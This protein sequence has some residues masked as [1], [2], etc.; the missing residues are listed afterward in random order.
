MTIAPLLW[1]IMYTWKY[2]QSISIN[3]HVFLLKVNFKQYTRSNYWTSD[4][5]TTHLHLSSVV[6]DWTSYE[7]SLRESRSG[8]DL[9][10]L[11]LKCTESY[12]GIS[13]KH[14]GLCANKMEN[15]KLPI[16]TRS[17][18]H[19]VGKVVL[20]HFICWALTF[21]FITKVCNSNGGD[22]SRLLRSERFHKSCAV[23]RL[24]AFREKQLIKIWCAPTGVLCKDVVNTTCKFPPSKILTL[25]GCHAI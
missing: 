22:S 6:W 13:N 24:I 11:S 8:V 7:Y 2:R 14:G 1:I 18:Y 3:P 17:L 25:I 9:Y 21:H 19:I 12:L 10:E 23:F 5:R 15:R 4:T 16:D 20:F